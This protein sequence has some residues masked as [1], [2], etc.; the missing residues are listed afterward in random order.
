MP[1]LAAVQAFA[2]RNQ[3]LTVVGVG[4]ALVTAFIAVRSFF[5]GST[6]AATTTT[7][8]LYDTTPTGTGGT[9]VTSSDIADLIAA[10][11]PATSSDGGG[12][13]SSGIDLAA[14]IAALTA[15]AS[16]PSSSAGTTVPASS[17]DGNE[18]NTTHGSAGAVVSTTADQLPTSS[19][20]TKPGISTPPGYVAAAPLTEAA[21]KAAIAARAKAEG[22][23][24]T[25]AG[26]EATYQKD[27]AA[28]AKK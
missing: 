6:A 11:T 2:K 24:P 26:I 28:A 14:L 4:A 19:L 9:G 17:S 16:S 21:A 25:A 3:T 27:L 10:M 18:Y 15:S 8:P 22:K 12:G 13:A 1:N 7:S 20:E 5:G 23:T